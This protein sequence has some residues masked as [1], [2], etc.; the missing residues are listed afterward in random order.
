MSNNI[1]ETAKEAVPVATAAVA[2][3]VASPAAMAI[4]MR[5]QEKQ[6]AK[7]CFCCCDYRRAVVAISVVFIVFEII[8]IILIATGSAATLV[9]REMNDLNLTQEEKDN[10]DDLGTL[11]IVSIVLS[12]IF[13]GCNIFAL[14]AAL[15]YSVCMLSTMVIVIL[16]QF[17]FNVYNA[18][19]LQTEIVDQAGGDFNSVSFIISIVISVICYGLYIYPVVGLISE[20]KSGIM[21]QETY[22]REAYSCCCNPKSQFN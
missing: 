16:I 15:K 4:N 11:G 21:S 19:A 13:L 9:T 8:S 6:G 7:C 22:P 14:C 2:I 1:E 12:V 17:G 10:L 18:W 3:P 5:D 20:I